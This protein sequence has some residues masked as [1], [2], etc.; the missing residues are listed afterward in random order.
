MSESEEQIL[1][2]ISGSIFDCIDFLNILID[3]CDLN[4][5]IGC[6]LGAL[7]ILN[8]ELSADVRCIDEINMDE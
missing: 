7:R 1:N 4:K 3:Q 6:Y 8:R 2:Q 5:N